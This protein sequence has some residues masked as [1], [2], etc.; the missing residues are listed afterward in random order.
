MYFG[1]RE[2]CLILVSFAVTPQQNYIKSKAVCVI[3][4]NIM[5]SSKDMTLVL[6]PYSPFKL[7]LDIQI[8]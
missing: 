4:I 6:E 5:K 7:S 3:V 1:W 8:I 2:N